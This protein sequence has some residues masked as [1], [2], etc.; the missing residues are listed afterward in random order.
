MKSTYFRNPFRAPGWQPAIVLL[1][2]VL[3]V[4]PALSV[5]VVW[6]DMSTQEQEEWVIRWD[7]PGSVRHS[8][9]RSSAP[10]QQRRGTQGAQQRHGVLAAQERGADRHAEQTGRGGVGGVGTDRLRGTAEVDVEELIER[11]ALDVALP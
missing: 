11:A 4:L 6:N 3:V 5:D 1:A 8:K 7:I 10:A 2:S 9:S